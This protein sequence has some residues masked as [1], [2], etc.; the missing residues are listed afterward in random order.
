[1]QTIFQ[2]FGVKIYRQ[3]DPVSP[4]PEIGQNLRHMHRQDVFHRLYFDND[5]AFHNEIGTI[6]PRQVYP[7]ANQRDNDLPSEGQSTLLQF[8]AKTLLIHVFQQTRPQRT[9]DF[10]RQP[11]DLPRAIPGSTIITSFF[12]KA[13]LIF[14]IF[15][16]HLADPIRTEVT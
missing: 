16:R 12:V 5:G 3:A 7:L 8:P 10:Y 9:M 11:N 13:C 2:E 15:V 1:M 14:L 6:S 4:Q